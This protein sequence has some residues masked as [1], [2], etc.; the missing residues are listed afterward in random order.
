[1]PLNEETKKRVPLKKYNEIL[2]STFKEENILPRDDNESMFVNKVFIVKTPT[3]S[4]KSTSLM[5][6]PLSLLMS[7]PQG[8]STNGSDM[9]ALGCDKAHRECIE[10]SQRILF[11]I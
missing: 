4:T 10:I 3:R 8:L 11:K 9:S 1:M 6:F 7:S 2:K 5:L